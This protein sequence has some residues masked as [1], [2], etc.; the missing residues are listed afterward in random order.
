MTRK[1]AEYVVKHME[2]YERKSALAK[3]C[4]EAVSYTLQPEQVCELRTYFY[5]IDQTQ[6][7]EIT[8]QDLKQ[9]VSA[10]LSFSP[11]DVASVFTR[12]SDGRLSYHEFLAAVSSR[13]SITENNLILAFEKIANHASF[14]T[15]EDILDLLGGDSVSCVGG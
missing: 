13:Q 12:H 10:H 7:S 8:L 9:A 15:W 11:E 3:V 14:F 6:T 5:A 4:M 2:S 1:G